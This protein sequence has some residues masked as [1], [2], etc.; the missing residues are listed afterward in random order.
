MCC[1][2]SRRHPIPP[3]VR[4]RAG[5]C[6][7][8][9]TCAGQALLEAPVTV[10]V[11]CLIVLAVL[12]LG[13][14]FFGYLTVSTVSADLCRV[15]AVDDSISGPLLTSYANDRLLALGGGAGLRVPGSLVVEVA[16]DKRSEVAVTVQ[17][18]QQPLPLIRTISAGL[19]PVA[20]RISATSRAAGTYHDVEGEPR[21]A[22]YQ[23]GNVT[24]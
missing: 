13:V 12:Q 17:I 20:V 6:A 18:A 3:R 2:T 15:V 24:P 5:R 19:V 21:D 9:R 1:C 22:P 23:F 7:V 4:L 16:G 8:L 11:T 14:W 10:L